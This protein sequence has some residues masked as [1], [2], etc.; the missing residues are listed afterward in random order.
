LFERAVSAVGLD[1]RAATPIWLKYIDFELQQSE[2]VRAASLFRRALAV[3]TADLG[4]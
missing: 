2:H 1:W 3:P 4:L